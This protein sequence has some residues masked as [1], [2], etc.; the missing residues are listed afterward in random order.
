MVSSKAALPTAPSWLSRTKNKD[1]RQKFHLKLKKA[2]EIAKRDE[3]FRRKREEDQNPRL[4]EVRVAR[5]VPATIDRKRVWDDVD[6]DQE[7]VLGLSVDVQQLKRHKL[8]AQQTTTGNGERQSHGGAALPDDDAVSDQDDEVDSMLDG[9]D[10]DAD[11][12]GDDEKGSYVGPETLD[13]TQERAL[14]PPRSSTAAVLDLLPEALSTKFSALLS[15]PEFPK[16]LI[17]TAI[18]GN[19][20][21]EAA[22]LTML[23]PNSTYIRRSAHRYAHKYSIREIS[24]FAAN[25]GYTTLLV[26]EE[27]YKRPSGLI[28][29]HLPSGPTFHF[30]ISNWIEG[31]KLPGHGNPTNH[32]P[33]LILNNFRTPLGLLTAHL[34]RSMFPLRPEL[35]GRQVVTLHNQRDYI[36]VRRYRYVFRDKRPTEKSITSTDGKPVK[37]VEDIKAGLQELGPR[38]TLKLR[39]IDQGI[40]RNSGQEWEWKPKMDKARTRFQM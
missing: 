39:R 32:Y 10:S 5:N 7:D 30:S 31:G 12:V 21:T 23:F 33:E 25:R 2:K 1:K 6:G 35:L 15:P 37:G 14:S 38:F 9:G 16:I 19:V 28:A 4:R 13:M 29:L 40:Q 27:Q 24:K 36:F 18:N 11:G 34:F 3:R 26:V 8:E 17:T 22:L 20:H